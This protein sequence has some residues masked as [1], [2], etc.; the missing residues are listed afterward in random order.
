MFDTIHCMHW[1]TIIRSQ[2]AIEVSVSLKIFLKYQ[3]PG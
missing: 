3:L 1:Y 2:I